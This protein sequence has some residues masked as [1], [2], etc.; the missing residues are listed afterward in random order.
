VSARSDIASKLWLGMP[1]T[2]NADAK[3]KTEQHLNDY[4]SEVLATMWSD[5]T[6]GGEGMWCSLCDRQILA[7]ASGTLGDL[8]DAAYAHLYATHAERLG[9]AA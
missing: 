8:T 2:D 7:E 5:F 1:S 3:A 6:V 4:R 9:G